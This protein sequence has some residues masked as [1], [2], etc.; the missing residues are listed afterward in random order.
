MK[1]RRSASQPPI[2]TPVLPPSELAKTLSGSICDSAPNMQST[3]RKPVRPRAAQA[4]G[5]TPLAMVPGG[6]VTSMARKTPLVVGD[7][8]RQHRADRAIAR[9]FGKEKVF[10]APPLARGRGAGP[11][12]EDMVL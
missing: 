3:M 7:V 1:G 9:F 4:A 12:D 11:V 8:G 10:F 6:A 5:S 2:E